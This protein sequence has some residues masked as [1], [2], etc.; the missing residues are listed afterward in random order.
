MVGTPK[1]I[2]D[3][4]VKYNREN[5]ILIADIWFEADIEHQ[6][7]EDGVELE[8]GEAIQV[9]QVIEN[10]HDANF[11]INWETISQAI[12]IIKEYNNELQR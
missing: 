12:R 9:M 10:T 5:T 7:K 3:Y 8:P 1:E 2:Y 6:A 11:G 4:L